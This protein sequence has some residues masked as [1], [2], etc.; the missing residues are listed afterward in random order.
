MNRIVFPAPRPPTYTAASFPTELVWMPD[1]GDR[2]RGGVAPAVL[3]RWPASEFL[4]LFFHGNGED[5]GGAV[6]FLRDLMNALSN[7]VRISV[8]HR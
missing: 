8:R 2:A 7:T 6:V 5:L 4:V 3:L 1:P